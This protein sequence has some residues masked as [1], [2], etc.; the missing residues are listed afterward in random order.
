MRFAVV[1]PYGCAL[2]IAAR[3]QDEGHEVK[4]YVDKGSGKERSEVLAHVGEGIVPIENDYGALTEWLEQSL[5]S[6]CLF[7]GSGLGDKADELRDRGILVVCAGVFCDRLENDRIFGQDIAEEAGASIPPFQ[8]FAS[9]TDVKRLAKSI[10]REVYFKTDKYLDADC[11]R[12]CD[13]A[14]ELVRYVTELRDQGISDRTRGILQD[15]VEGVAISIGRWWNGTTWVGPYLNDI[16]LKG[17]GNDDFGPSTSCALNVVW[18]AEE[19]DIAEKLGW[20]NLTARFRSE[21]APPGFYDIN[22]I[23]DEKGEPWFLEWTP[24]IGY[25]SDPTGFRL[26][27]DLGGWLEHVVL[28]TG[29]ATFSKDIAYSIHLSVPPYPWQYVNWNDEKTCVGVR[30][31]GT[32]GVW[33]G[34]FVGYQ[35]RDVGK[36]L[37][38]AS[39]EGSIGL[40]IAVGDSLSEL[41]EECVAF[42]DELDCSGIFCRTDGDKK[43]KEIA[44]KLAAAGI[45]THEGLVT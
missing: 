35:V 13:N 44:E 3:L 20:E 2:S 18:F 31:H 10:D 40:S 37:E 28:G 38:V 33:D 22:S 15:N 9:L 41:N 42:A 5:D 32:D 12:G 27:D 16:E 29:G 39:P 45:K 14:E 23:I 11:S 1:D 36:G 24:R 43:I 34:N 6:I 25:D 21:N 19:S 8:A 4:F 30:V 17:Y 7:A 26:I